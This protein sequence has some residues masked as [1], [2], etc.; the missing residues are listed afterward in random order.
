MNQ[1]ELVEAI[2]KEVKRVLTMRGI[3]ISSSPEG[4]NTATFS[5]VSSTPEVSSPGIIDQSIGNCDLTGKQV[6]TQRDLEAFEG[7]S[8][9]VTPRAVIT[10]LA[11]DYAREKGITIT[12]VAGT[13]AQNSGS[14]SPQP[15]ATVAL[16]I[17]PDFPSDSTIVKKFL[18]SRGLQV[19]E[20]SGKSYE[21]AISNLTGA[22]SSGTANFG[23]CVEKSGMEGTIHANRN[24]SIRAVHCRDTMEAR[25][26]RVDIGANVIVLD[27]VSNPEAVIGGYMGV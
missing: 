21:A 16:V 9:T 26:A 25:A 8:I 13:G 2:I 1:N 12:K 4:S 23:V 14:V 19:K 27:A 20:L 5:A 17:A 10:P 18:T 11:H 6:I 24:K 7:Q 15:V 3:P 22:V